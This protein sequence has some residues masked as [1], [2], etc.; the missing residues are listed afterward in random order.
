[1]KA[2][3]QAF[4]KAYLQQAGG[5]KT[6]LDTPG[7]GRPPESEE[8]RPP[9]GLSAQGSSDAQVGGLRGASLP[10]K[11]PPRLSEPS[12]GL[13]DQTHR[14]Q[15]KS[16]TPNEQSTDAPEA[17]KHPKNWGP[18]G[19]TSGKRGA[20]R[21]VR[22]SLEETLSSETRQ[23]VVGLPNRR[24]LE[25]LASGASGAAPPR[26]TIVPRPHFLSMGRKKL[27]H[28]EAACPPPSRSGSEGG[29]DSPSVL[30][31][32][33]SSQGPECILDFT[34]GSTE[35]AATPPT[36]QEKPPKQKLPKNPRKVTVRDLAIPQEVC[37]F[38]PPS[39]TIPLQ[40]E[41]GDRPKVRGRPELAR[42]SEP[43]RLSLVVFDPAQ[44]GRSV[45]PAA[46]KASSAGPI[47]GKASRGEPKGTWPSEQALKSSDPTP[48]RPLRLHSP[49]EPSA[50][51]GTKETMSRSASPKVPAADRD[52]GL[53]SAEPSK[54][55]S[56]H[57]RVARLHWPSV[58]FALEAK[59]LGALDRVADAILSASR[60]GKKICGFVSLRRGEGTT[61]LLL[62]AA[63]RLADGRRRLL[64]ADANLQH[65]DLA[66]RLN[67]A[68]QATWDQ[69][70]EAK[71]RL[72]EV[73]IESP[74]EGVTILPLAASNPPE[75]ERGGSCW[76]WTAP[77][78]T[79]LRPFYDLILVDLGALE[80]LEQEQVLGAESSFRPV[81]G[82]VVVRNGRVQSDRAETAGLRRM[83]QAAGMSVIGVVDNCV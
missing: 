16:Q 29:G 6:D 11:K 51:S 83:L 14:R 40:A 26:P 65:P 68:A 59:A 37:L 69:A 10:A 71:R 21:T 18:R 7:A 15:K 60:D 28:Q 47:V 66:D 80:D 50:S 35:K 3:D 30:I 78:L 17:E 19:K 46:D 74:A 5:L 36:E 56:P 61:T 49:P 20:S 39:P 9:G 25:Q 82:L 52:P 13:S 22:V 23:T 27:P 79:E 63:R 32:A 1:M 57:W 12:S 72:E 4:I 67:L 81:E 73:L 24:A 77:G 45:G 54:A 48:Q 64:L 62:C 33:D 76:G 38:E 58:C 70:V 55:F 75:L 34:G 42:P 53:V 43:P 31:E 8:E 41:A 44:E 2:L